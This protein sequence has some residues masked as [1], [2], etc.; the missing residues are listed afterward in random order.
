M[1]KIIPFL[2]IVVLFLSLFTLKV[3]T[4]SDITAVADS[5]FSNDNYTS[6]EFAPLQVFEQ[7]TADEFKS[8]FLKNFSS[9]VA[10][11]DEYASLGIE[12]AMKLTVDSVGQK[13]V[14]TCRH[15]EASLDWLNPNDRY[16]Y[17]GRALVSNK[18]FNGAYNLSDYDGI[19]FW[20]GDYRGTL[21]VSLHRANTGGGENLPD[22]LGVYGQAGQNDSGV[23]FVLPE[24]IPDENGY[25]KV[26]FGYMHGGWT[27]WEVGSFATELP[28][29]DTLEFEFLNQKLPMGST[30]YVGDFKLYNEISISE[31]AKLEAVIN[32][33]EARDDAPEKAELI[34]EAR[35]ALESGKQSDIISARSKLILSMKDDVLTELYSN[36]YQ[37][38]RDRI[39][40]RGYSP[41][42]L[43]GMYDGMYIRDAACQILM[44]LAQ[45]DTD[46]ARRMLSYIYGVFQELGAAIPN[47]VI[48]DLNE[49]SYGNNDGTSVGSLR[50]LINLGGTA[51]AEQEISATKDE[52]I[53]SVG[54]WLSK[55]DDAYGLIRAEL[56]RDGKL[57]STA[58]LK[59]SELDTS[60]Q[61]AVFEFSLPL[62]PV[63]SGSY[64]L[65][66]SA[67]DSPEK[68]VV[69]YGKS[70][71]RG[72]KTTL[73]GKS[74][75][76]EASFEAFK[77]NLQYLSTDIQP[78]AINHVAYAWTLYANS[79]P[80][81]EVDKK[82]IAESFP[83]VLKYSEEFFK[84]EYFSSTLKLVRNPFFEHSREGRKWNSYDLLTNVFVSQ[85]SYNLSAI[86][87]K[88]GYTE[89]ADELMDMALSIRDGINANLVAEANGKQ[90]YAELIDVDHSDRFILGMSWVNISPNAVNWFGMDTEIMQNTLDY[91]IENAPLTYNGYKMLDACYTLENGASGNHVIGK[92]FSW[93][94][95]FCFNSDNSER[96]NMLTD[97]LVVNS[98]PKRVFTESWW[99]PNRFSDVGNQEHA[100]WQAYA[101][102]SVYPQGVAVV[103][104]LAKDI[105]DDG[106]VSVADALK[107][108][109]I[110]IFPKEYYY[111]E[112]ELADVD[113]D[114][115]VTVSDALQIL[116][117]A[118]GII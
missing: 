13:I 87:E 81:T 4:Y 85:T 53:T 41:T 89:K 82:F 6:Y 77:H 114:G 91:Y 50:P 118:A 69:W 111:A 48:S 10:F 112:H 65:R 62:T 75:N 51:V 54:V 76:G 97:F 108:L 45:G 35:A 44:H 107:A 43:T 66:L 101:V 31:A 25:V 49:T 40:N 38:L 68:T 61:F 32:E 79:A 83:I 36:T 12:S 8:L 57:I 93:E 30:L 11:T 17:D 115:S 5:S 73:D 37:S 21:K 15:I 52:T 60:R 9:T 24:V 105:D 42:S 22:P 46:I 3:D 64:T 18:T 110:A 90:I 34:S 7:Y 92:G 88:L 14:S 98:S 106:A 96:F 100:S 47:H 55:K 113:K 116:R 58:E 39:N 95:M 28:T 20:V 19:M 56:L 67:P 78:D 33:V 104:R 94:L 59:A 71:Y 103:E 102:A 72:L 63:R 2:L 1:K 16:H 29:L 23:Y 70:N 117:I 26:P 80:D 74:V 99:L 84:P 109:R 27:W 86:A